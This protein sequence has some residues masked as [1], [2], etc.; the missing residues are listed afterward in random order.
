MLS[1]RE[2]GGFWKLTCG[3]NVLDTEGPR[4]TKALTKQ[5]WRSQWSMYL[6][7]TCSL[8]FPDMQNKVALLRPC[9]NSPRLPNPSKAHIYTNKATLLS[10]FPPLPLNH[11]RRQRSRKERLFA[12]SANAPTKKAPISYMKQKKP[13]P[14]NPFPQLPSPPRDS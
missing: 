2:D 14:N 12:A 11:C 8:F 9:R 4:C 1:V 13:L 3:D 10:L 5:V 6:L 7:C